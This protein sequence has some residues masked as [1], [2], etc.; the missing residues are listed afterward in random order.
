MEDCT[1]ERGLRGVGRAPLEAAPTPALGD[2]KP[3]KPENL[4]ARGQWRGQPERSL[5]S[6]VKAREVCSGATRQDPARGRAAAGEAG[7][8]REPGGP[9]RPRGSQGSV[10]TQTPQQQ[11]G[12]R[13]LQRRGESCERHRWRKPRRQLWFPATPFTWSLMYKGWTRP[14]SSQIPIQSRS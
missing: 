8:H 10:T 1:G 5:L 12:E 13:R 9:Q 11:R 4:N 2:L 7:R 3:L 14:K 6:H